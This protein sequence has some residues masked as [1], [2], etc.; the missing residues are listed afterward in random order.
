MSPSVPK[1]TT[2]WRSRCSPSGL[3]RMCGTVRDGRV[4]T[5][6]RGRCAEA[7]IL[8]ETLHTRR[9]QVQSI[10]ISTDTGAYRPS[11]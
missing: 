10:S 1:T 7:P 11:D 9:Q 8:P 6:F 4:R 2:S 5:G 3:E